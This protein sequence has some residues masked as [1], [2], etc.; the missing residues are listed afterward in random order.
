MP[1]QFRIEVTQAD[2]DAARECRFDTTAHQYY[3]PGGHSPACPPPYSSERDCPIAQALQRMGY[4]RGGIRVHS[5]FLTVNNGAQMGALGLT[6]PV[7]GYRATERIRR[8]MRDWDYHNRATP[9]T[10][11]TTK[12]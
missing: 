1:K 9:A 2:I 10:F 7:E 11:V 5:D 4:A 3:Q 12:L 8:Y 6:W